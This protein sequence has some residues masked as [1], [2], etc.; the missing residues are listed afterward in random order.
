MDAETIGHR[1]I[2]KKCCGKYKLTIFGASYD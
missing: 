2:M 1:K